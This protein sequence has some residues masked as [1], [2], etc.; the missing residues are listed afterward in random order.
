MRLIDADE[1]SAVTDIRNDG[2]EFTYVPYSEIE[3]AETAYDID[4]VVDALQK[5]KEYYKRFYEAEG[6][7]KED[8][9]IHKATQLVFDSAIEIVKRAGK[10]NEKEI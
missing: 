1:L 2:K 6:K 4:K 7:T 9:Y 3:N 10:I 5:K 8:E